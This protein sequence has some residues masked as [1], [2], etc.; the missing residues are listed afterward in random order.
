MELLDVKLN[1]DLIVV[2]VPTQRAPVPTIRI[3]RNIIAAFTGGATAVACF[4][5]QRPQHCFWQPTFLSTTRK[6]RVANI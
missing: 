1:G 5:T 2:L 3:I 6:L 4:F